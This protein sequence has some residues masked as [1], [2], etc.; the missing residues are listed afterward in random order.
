MCDTESPNLPANDTIRNI[1][2]NYLQNEK[3]LV[4]QLYFTTSH[5]PT[6][7]GFRE[8]IWKGMFE[9]IIPKK[10]VIEQSV[11]IIDSNGNVSH[12][13]DLAI[14][15]ETY[16][17][18]IFHYG[19]LK[20]IPIEAVAVVIEC[21]SNSIKAK[22]LKSWAERVSALKTSSDSYT[23][24]ISQIVVGKEIPSPTQTSTRPLRILCC[25]KECISNEKLGSGEKSFDF[26]IR[27]KG[28]RQGL[29]IDINDSKKNLYDW[30]LDLN[31]RNQPEKSAEGDDKKRSHE[32]YSYKLK[33]V[34]LDKYQVEIAEKPVALLTLNLQLN[35]LL[36]LINNPMLFPHRAYADMFNKCKLEDKVN[37]K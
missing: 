27:S 9:Q 30:Y 12:E 25:L 13:V 36:M 17:P 18:Y 28:K 16:T 14:F 32:T 23:R 15:D 4:N 8:E 19:K 26:I 22:K 7:G 33:D 34:S 31:H 6:I 21:K 1:I 2:N 5:G 11:F 3:S 29:Q 35:Q 10:F 24:T 20:F 37:G